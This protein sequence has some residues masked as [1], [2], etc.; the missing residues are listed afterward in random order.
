MNNEVCETSVDG[1]VK[2]DFQA[3]TRVGATFML[4]VA[5]H[6]SLKFTWSS[7]VTTRIGGDFDNFALSYFYNW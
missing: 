2:H 4:P 3:N 5:R 1:E 6:H 7:G